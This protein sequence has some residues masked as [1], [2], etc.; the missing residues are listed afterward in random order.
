M[1]QPA[2][3]NLERT[4]LSE[5]IGTYSN[6]ELRTIFRRLNPYLLNRWMSH[7]IQKEEYEVCQIIKEVIEEEQ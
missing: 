3:Q 2:T 7:F 4:R 1:R 5:N 6:D